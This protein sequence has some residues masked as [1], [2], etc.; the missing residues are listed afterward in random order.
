[1]GGEQASNGLLEAGPKMGPVLV[2]EDEVDLLRTY[3]RLLRW[4]GCD[5][6]TAESGHEGLAIAQS[7]HVALAIV[8]LKL[9]DIEG[10][11]VVRALRAGHDPPVVIV[12]TGFVS[13]QSRQAALAAGAAEYLGKPF[14]V[15]TFAAL[16]RNVL[17]SL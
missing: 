17:G 12:V 11:A 15:L 2:I 14:S 8:D 16:L 5:V 6:I 7:R 13:A 9:P 1:M 3:E 4:M 10:L